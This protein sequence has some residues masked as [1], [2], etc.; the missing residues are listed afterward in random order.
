MGD[1]AAGL[2]PG[3]LPHSRYNLGKEQRKQGVSGHAPRRIN[4]TRQKSSRVYYLEGRKQAR[5]RG[6]KNYRGTRVSTDVIIK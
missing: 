6:R 3:D 5:K 1:K 4:E 2:C